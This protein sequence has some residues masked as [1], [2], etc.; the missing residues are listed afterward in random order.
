M[1]GKSS[2]L[3]SKMDSDVHRSV[4]AFVQG[5]T[6]ASGQPA[7]QAQA[8]SFDG[9]VWALPC[10]LR[11]CEAEGKVTLTRCTAMDV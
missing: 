10:P 7:P 4:A 11:E 1:S 2:N 8:F 6:S 5:T 3:T 9:C